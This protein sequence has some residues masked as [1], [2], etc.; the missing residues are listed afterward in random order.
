MKIFQRG[1]F[2]IF[3]ILF[4]QVSLA[5]YRPLVGSDWAKDH[6]GLLPY[7]ECH[8]LTNDY[9]K[10]TALVISLSAERYPTYI[11]CS[12][13]SLGLNYFIPIHYRE[14]P[15]EGGLY[16][17]FF[18]RT[19]MINKVKVYHLHQKTLRDVMGSYN[20]FTI[21]GGIGIGGEG[22]FLSNAADAKIRTEAL[23]A[24]DFFSVGSARWSFALSNSASM[25][26]CTNPQV[27]VNGDTGGRNSRRD[28]VPR[29][30]YDAFPPRTPIPA[31]DVLAL[32]FVKIKNG[33]VTP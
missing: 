32:R 29:G 3:A 19:S 23:T 12:A 6:P 2:I 22:S 33:L 18:M 7:E 21:A 15:V 16:L 1:F 27:I 9:L 5:D 25:S 28:C 11:S 4:S 17:S 30:P 10:M 14:E 24:F 26:D 8:L 13:K 31:D 20:G